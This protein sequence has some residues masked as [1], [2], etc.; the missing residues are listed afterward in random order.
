MND[1]LLNSTFLDLHS[2]FQAQNVKVLLGG[3][4]GLY[5][6]QL[7][8]LDRDSIKTLL[9]IDAWPLPRSTSDL[10]L[11]FPIEVLVNLN[12][13]Q[14]VRQTIDDL[15]FTPIESSRYW[16]FVQATSKVKVDL[17]TGPVDDQTKTQL[18]I[19]DRRVR[20]KGSLKLHARYTPEALE[21]SSNQESIAIKGLLSNGLSYDGV[22]NIPSPFT[23]LMMKITAF[24]D[25][26]ENTNKN[27]G[28]HHA[29]DV[30]RIVAMLTERQYDMT[31]N[32]MTRNA[33]SSYSKR[34]KQLAHSL[35][36][37]KSDPGILRMKEHDFYRDSMDLDAFIVTL[38]DLVALPS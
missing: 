16:Q 4:F 8:L 18:K 19:D 12:D 35:F 38:K 6:K 32:Q 26:V 13:M 27:F 24:G 31:I 14:A 28:R 36:N 20:P 9:S 2:K 15:N 3:G 17:L 29:L 10:D 30:Y 5:L 11:F 25:Q 33:K 23:Y 1:Q 22:V 7:D 21:L 34:V 37:S